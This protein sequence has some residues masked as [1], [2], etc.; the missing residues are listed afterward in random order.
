MCVCIFNICHVCVCLYL[1]V[2]VQVRSYT[3]LILFFMCV[4]VCVCVFVCVSRYATICI[5]YCY[6]AYVYV[7]VCVCVCIY[8]CVWVGPEPELRYGLTSHSHLLF[9]AAELACPFSGPG[10]A[11]LPEGFSVHIYLLFTPHIHSCATS[12]PLVLHRRATPTRGLSVHISY[13]H[14][15]FTAARL[16]H[17]LYCTGALRLPEGFPCTPPMQTLYS[18]LRD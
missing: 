2:C 18:Q 10:A 11:R 16:A 14:P 13:L 3:Y 1:F 5:F 17:P 9:T 4:C 15:V 7:C 8:V 12:P 6:F